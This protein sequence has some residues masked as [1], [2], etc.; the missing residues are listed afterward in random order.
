MGDRAGCAG[1]RASRFPT[2]TSPGPSRFSP[3]RRPTTRELGERQGPEL[4]LG[5]RATRPLA[6]PRRMPPEPAADAHLLIG[7]IPLPVA[8]LVASEAEAV[9][10]RHN[11]SPARRRV[12]PSL[13]AT[14]PHGPL[15]R[16]WLLPAK[17]ILDA[18]PARRRGWRCHHRARRD[19]AAPRRAGR[20]PQA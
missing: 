14:A 4:L 3:D 16:P 20:D 5:R 15:R 9:H 1:G 8:G 7:A 2:R 13:H 19:R 12:V 18:T 17:P 6:L 10:L 11:R